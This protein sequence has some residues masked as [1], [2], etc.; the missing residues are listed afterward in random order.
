MSR[1]STEVFLTIHSKGLSLVEQ[2]T[3][4]NTSDLDR[5]ESTDGKDKLKLSNN[6]VKQHRINDL[7]SFCTQGIQLLKTVQALLWKE[8][9]D[10]TRH[11]K[12]VHRTW[13]RDVLACIH[14]G[15]AL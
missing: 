9:L 15:R 14:G 11:F 4:L 3:V 6:E 8:L 10:I 2:A 13:S 7:D 12:K 5:R 1:W